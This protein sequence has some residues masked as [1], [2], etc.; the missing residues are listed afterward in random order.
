MD[1]KILIVDDEPAN[2]RLLERLF[3]GKY[4]VVSALSGA[5]ALELLAMHDVALI[6]SDQRMPGMTGIEFLMRAAEIRPQVVR[7]VLTGYTDVNSLVEAINSGVV[8]KYVTKPW[9]NPEL[10]QTVDRALEHYETIKSQHELKLQNQRLEALLEATRTNFVNIF[11]DMLGAEDP[12]ALE[13]AR[14][15]SS[16]AVAIGQNL[17]LE[18]QDLR[19]LSLAALLHEIEYVGISNA[20][21]LKTMPYYEDPPAEQKFE[22][23]L[24]LLSSIPDFEELAFT[25]RHQHEKWDG[26]GG[27]KGFVGEQSPLHSRIIAVAAA[28][29]E[30]TSPHPHSSQPPLT[31]DEAIMRLQLEGARKFDPE[32]VGVFCEMNQTLKVEV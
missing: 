4:T 9:V 32:V 11:V 14:R 1:Y 27:P 20:P 6:I 18:V 19:Q 13:H 30:M 25:I 7:I 31:R 15:T 22:W 29:D 24:Q 17:G 16:Y 21:L 2:I 8:Y 26:S 3:R 28:Y 10:L 23:R 12:P 5:E